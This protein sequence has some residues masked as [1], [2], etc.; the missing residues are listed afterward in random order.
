MRAAIG[1]TLQLHHRQRLA[2]ARGDLCIGRFLHAQ[3]EGDIFKHRHMREEGV[4]LKHRI[5]VAMLGGGIGDIAVIQHHPTAVDR[6][7]PGDQPQ[8][9]GFAAA[10]RTEQGNKFAVIDGQVE[11]ADN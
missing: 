9:S 1:E 4:A 3:A 8:N 11:V 10:R 2:D 5:D 7:Q 6:F